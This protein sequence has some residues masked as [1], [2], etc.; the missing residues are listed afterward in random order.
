MKTR[1][2]LKYFVNY[3]SFIKAIFEKLTSTSY[4]NVIIDFSYSQIFDSTKVTVVNLFLRNYYK[5]H[6]PRNVLKASAACKD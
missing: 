2:S 4:F 6:L 5:L 3:C 1:V